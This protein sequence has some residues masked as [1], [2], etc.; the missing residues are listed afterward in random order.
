MIKGSGAEFGKMT[1]DVLVGVF[2]SGV[3]DM[4]CV[5]VVCCK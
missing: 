1:R 3:V 5:C 4:V 2:S